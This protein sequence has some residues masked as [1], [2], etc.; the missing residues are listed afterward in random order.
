MLD[1]N[2]ASGGLSQGNKGLVMP[3]MSKTFVF[4]FSKPKE[5]PAQSREAGYPVWKDIEYVRVQQPG[6]RDP[7]ELEAHDGHRQRW[8]AEY[9]RYKQGKA[10]IPD[11]TPLS[12]LLPGSDAMVITMR[13]LGVYTVEQLASISD[14]AIG[15]IPFGGELKQRAKKYLETMNGSQGFN[16]MQAE[17]DAA[18]AETNDLKKMIAD[19]KEQMETMKAPPA[20]AGAF[21][22]NML[23]AMIASTVAATQASQPRRG[24]PP[25]AA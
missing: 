13:T 20:P 24:R 10:Q 17:V 4:F 15:N 11:G 9:E 6:E 23:Q 8:P 18:K 2:Y 3:D 21:D 19:L 25:K 14:S 1:P 5:F 12:I 22:P 7:V 16:K